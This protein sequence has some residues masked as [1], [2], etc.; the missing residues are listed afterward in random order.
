MTRLE[1]EKE[2]D[3]KAEMEA[4]ALMGPRLNMKIRTLGE[5]LQ[6]MMKLEEDNIEC[7]DGDGEISRGKTK[8]KR[9]KEKN[10]RKIIYSSIL[11]K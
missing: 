7:I 2:F 11:H 5:I 9:T 1:L 3:Q 10:S 6:E 4:A 8:K